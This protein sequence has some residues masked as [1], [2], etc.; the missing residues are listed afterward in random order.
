MAVI[1]GLLFAPW[2]HDEMIYHALSQRRLDLSNEH[3]EIGKIMFNPLYTVNLLCVCKLCAFWIF[4][5]LVSKPDIMNTT[6]HWEEWNFSTCLYHVIFLMWWKTRHLTLL[7]GKYGTLSFCKILIPWCCYYYFYC[8]QYTVITRP[9]S[10]PR[11]LTRRRNVQF[12]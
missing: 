11:I 10:Q 6:L 7:C 3:I 8:E 9:V 1:W 5:L 4:N 12:H 2:L